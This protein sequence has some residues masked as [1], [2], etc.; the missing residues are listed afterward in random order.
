MQN[1]QQK[2]NN[3]LADFSQQITIVENIIINNAHGKSGLISQITNHLFASGGKRI[4]PI[5]LLASSQICNI[6]TNNQAQYN[7]AAAIEI[8]HTATLLHDDVIDNSQV[9]RGKKTANALH[10]NKSSILVGDYLFSLAFQLMV[11]ANNMQALDV[12]AKA[13]STIADGEVLQLQYSSDINITYSQYCDIIFGKTAALFAAACKV[14]AIISGASDYQI[15]ALHQFGSDLGMI[16]QIIDDILDYTANEQ[17]LG[18][19]IGGDFFEGKITLPAIIAL[20]QASS[21]DKALISQLFSDNYHNSQPN[22][23]N[24]TTIIDLF[25]KYNAIEQSFAIAQQFFDSAS[26][27]LAIFSTN[28][29]YLHDILQYSL[30]RSC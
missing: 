7:L 2:F 23:Q 15:N 13:S 24:L 17:Q 26:K 4:R 20:Q 19:A 25:R 11:I 5:L 6:D 22:Q 30:S 9:R 12:L 16:F 29:T 28:K 18:K 27:Q 3:L 21:A 1:Q 14:G 10:D 8:I